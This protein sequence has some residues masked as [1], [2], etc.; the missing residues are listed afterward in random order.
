MPNY[1]VFAPLC[2]VFFL[3]VAVAAPV[4]AV[5]YT[6]GVTVGQ[7]VKY[8]NFVGSGP[9]LEDFSNIDSQTLQV[10]SVAGTQVTLLSTGKYKN[11]TATQGNGTVSVWDVSAGTD[12]GIP[13][14]QGPIIAANLNAGDPIPPLGTYS[15]NSTENRQYLGFT[16]SV[17]ILSVSISTPDYNSTL[18]Y[19]YDKASGMF[20]EAQSQTTTQSDPEPVTSQYSYSITETNIFSSTPTPTPTGTSP[21]IPIEYLMILV[22][23][24]IAVVVVVV[25]ILFR[26]RI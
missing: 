2:L 1:K 4:L 9:G 21:I 13:T 12:N 11:G 25:L 20:L 17:N 22:V 8:G 16:R 6:P 3:L 19:V 5:T 23:V 7:Y 26:K 18:N 10:T 14:T 15:V 24:I